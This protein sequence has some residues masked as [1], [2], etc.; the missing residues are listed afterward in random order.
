[1]SLQEEITSIINAPDLSY[2]EKVSRLSQ[3]VTEAEIR[4]LLPKPQ[5]A[6][7]TLKAPLPPVS[8][9]IKA[10]NLSIHTVYLKDIKTGAKK[11]EYRDCSDYYIGRCTYTENGKTYLTPYNVIRFYVAKT[12]RLTVALTD[13]TCDGDFFMFHLGEILSE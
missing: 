1:M 3:Y 12:K 7:P 6:P 2:E 11:I 10:L 13:I 9:G 5:A 4:M 8:Q